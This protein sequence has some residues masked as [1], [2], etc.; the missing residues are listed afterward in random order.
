MNTFLYH[1]GFCDEV[2]HQKTL[3]P[4]FK[5]ARVISEHKER[6]TVKNELGNFDAE[7]MG[8]LRFSAQSR[9]DFPA[10]GDWVSISIYDDNKAL[11]HEILYRKNK[12]QRKSIGKE[13]DQ[14]IIATNVDYA[15]IVEGVNRDF[16]INRLER[17]ITICLDAKITPIVVINKI[18]LCNTAELEQIKKEIHERIPQYLLLFTSCN[19]L[20]GID[21]LSA[22]IL[23][24]K[25]YCFLG[26][27]GVGKSTMIN[28]LIGEEQLKTSAISQNVDRGKHTTSHRELFVLKD[29]GIV[30]DNPGMRE[31]GI[32]NADQGLKDSFNQIQQLADQCKYS[33]CTH[34]HEKGCAVLEAIDSGELNAESYHNYIKLYKEQQHYE[35][36]VTD[37][38]RKEKNLSKLI[39]QVKT[40][41]PDK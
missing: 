14:Q 28:Q 6:Y 38:K 8:N 27:S 33:D 2:L 12:L 31:V 29:G 11:I 37:R 16:N 9:A 7:I 24:E 20:E 34:T 22:N 32:A 41:R 10:V 25:T 36:S 3:S 19:S 17:Y 4:D 23:P 18:D 40:K 1:L 5:V 13:S 35:S 26:S 21:T 39:K 30:I 15:F